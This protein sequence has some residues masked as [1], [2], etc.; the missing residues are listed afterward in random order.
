MLYVLIG[1][2]IVA[3]IDD[4][5]KTGETQELPAIPI[6]P[7]LALDKT[8]I[9]RFFG[10]GAMG[11][12]T[13]SEG[14]INILLT[15]NPESLN[16]YFDSGPFVAGYLFSNQTL[17]YNATEK[18]QFALQIGLQ[19]FGGS[20]EPFEIW[21]QQFP[22]VAQAFRTDVL[23]LPMM[24][25][26]GFSGVIFSVLDLLNLKAD[27]IVS[28]F[29]VAGISELTAY[30]G[31]LLYKVSSTFLPFFFLVL[32]LGYFTES[33]LFGNGGRWLAAIMTM[34]LYVY[35]TAPLGA[36][37]AK[38]FITRDFKSA[39]SIFPGGCF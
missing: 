11:N 28:Q 16:D 9:I 3:K 34:L 38:K 22:Y 10:M 19:L 8:G 37:I 36:L 32:F 15:E 26:F 27:N 2:L 13:D 5:T 18:S 1:F 6:S 39:A 23:L 7:L 21:L 30:L 29:R 4:A 25:V 31:V 14:D 33:T 24:M 17:Q 20:T 35:S 12:F